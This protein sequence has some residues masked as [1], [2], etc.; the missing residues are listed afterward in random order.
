MNRK[1]TLEAINALP[2][3][4]AKFITDTGEYRITYRYPHALPGGHGRIARIQE[5]QESLACYTD[6][7][8][9]ALGTAKHMSEQPNPLADY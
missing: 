4:Q 9:D 5:R 7:R 6:D 8:E 3:I 2:G 1:Q